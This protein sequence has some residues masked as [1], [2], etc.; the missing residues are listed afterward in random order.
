MGMNS[1]GLA[2]CAALLALCAACEFDQGGPPGRG[3]LVIAVDALRYDHL[4]LGG[5]DRP[6]SP[7]LDQLARE[8]VSFRNA[9]AAAPRQIPAH[10]A[11]LSA[12]DPRL[13]RRILPEDVQVNQATLWNWADDAPHPA[14]TFLSQGFST[15]AFYDHPNL[16]PVYGYERGF[17]VYQGPARN[18]DTGTPELGSAAVFRRFDRWLSQNPRHQDWFAYLEVADLERV[19][20]ERDERWDTYFPP[21]PELARVP[22]VGDAQHLFFAVPRSRWPGGMTTWGEYEA[23]YDGAILEFDGALARLRA[24]LEQLGRLENTTVVVVG[25]YGMSFGESGLMLDSGTLSDCDLH[26]PL[27]VRPAAALAVRSGSESDALVSTCDVLPTLLELAGLRSEEGLD[28]RS[29]AEALTRADFSGREVVHASCA[30]QEGYAALDREGCFERTWPGR[31]VDAR[32]SASWFGDP[33]LRPDVLR[34]V[35]HD[36]RAGGLGHLEDAPATSEA[37]QRLAA[38]AGEW[39]RKVEGR[40]ARLQGPV[41]P[42]APAAPSSARR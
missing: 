37:A 20:G 36:R 24:R 32:L 22:P 3:V 9:F 40:R 26:V 12:C 2:G 15:A 4:G 30:F 39:S 6:T 27:I 25:A 11:L 14:A 17:G 34:E 28:G 29:F 33:G 5:Y 38:A 42:L 21:R 35:Y 7:T 18:P 13:A 19:W 16:A 10:V 41:A 1:A 23:R 8:G 31:G